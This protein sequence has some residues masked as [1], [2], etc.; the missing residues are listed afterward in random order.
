MTDRSST[1][2]HAQT[3]RDISIRVN[4]EELPLNPF[5]RGFIACT[6]QGMISALKTPSEPH[7]ID[8]HLKVE[9]KA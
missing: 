2:G 7:T 3:S 8:I 9:R 1:P 6:L 4:D 5:V